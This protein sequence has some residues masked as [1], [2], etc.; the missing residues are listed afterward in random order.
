LATVEVSS[1][2]LQKMM[3]DSGRSAFITLSRS[4]VRASPLTM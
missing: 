3:A 2:V 1:R 4:R